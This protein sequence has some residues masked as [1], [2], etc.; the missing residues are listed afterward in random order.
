[1]PRSDAW[2]RRALA[3]GV[4]ASLT[5]AACGTSSTSPSAATA[6]PSL[7]PGDTPAPT[8]EASQA[9]GTIY[10]FTL[11]EEWDDVDP[12]RAYTGED[13]A[14][15]G[16]TIMRSL[17]SFV[18]SPDPVVANTLQPDLATDTGTPTPDA[19][20]WSFTLRDGVSWQDGSELTCEDVKYG[21]SRTFATDIITNGPTYAIQYLDIAKADDGTSQYKG[22]YTGEGQDLFDQAVTCEGKTITFRLNQPVADF[23]Y[24]V[25]LGFSPVPE[26]MD[27]GE[28]YTNEVFSNGPYKIEEY[29]KGNGGHFLL[30][31]NENWNRDSDPIR[32]A[33]PDQWEILFGIDP[34]IGDQRLIASQ[35]DDAFTIGYTAVQPENLTTVFAD[36]ETA[37]PY[38]AGRAFSDYDPFARYYWVDTK[39]IPNVKHRQALAVALD[40]DAVRANLGGEF[41]GALGDGVIK[42]NLGDQYAETGLWTGLLGKEIADTGDPEY[43]MQLIEESGE[44]MPALTWDYGQTPVRD[45]EAAIV[46]S[47]LARAGIEVTANPIPTG[48]YYGI[49]FDDEQ[50]HQFG[51]AGWGPDWPNA[52][53]V[54]APL[55]TNDGG[56]NLSRVEDPDFVAR[57]QTAL[58]ELDHATQAKMWQD[59]NKEAMENVFVIPTTFGLNQVMGG[60]KVG[61]LYQ[62]APYGSWPY[63]ELYVMP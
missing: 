46:V 40:R 48:Q 47:S 27:T 24:T 35:G 44:P 4:I 9:G 49:V 32:P 15:F 2:L 7:A 17:T 30:T 50:A 25:T 31:R 1:M 20:E 10:M 63:A 13:L 62:W 51:W 16:A 18:W 58:R 42:P 52:S 37:N 12:Q 60:N 54:I 11:S 55:F 57:V 41:A 22:P 3:F 38:F 56:W 26:A 36:P 21:V 61:G 29:T 34:K 5:L 8:E 53:T 14:F 23:N 33:Y 45:Q 19:T 43:A 6:A 28:S 59:L 39:K